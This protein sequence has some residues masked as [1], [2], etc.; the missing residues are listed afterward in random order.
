LP[1]EGADPLNDLVAAIPLVIVA[2]MPGWYVLKGS[3]LFR[4]TALAYVLSRI[5]EQR[6]NDGMPR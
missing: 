6:G 4:P 2:L 1:P 3:P 5:V